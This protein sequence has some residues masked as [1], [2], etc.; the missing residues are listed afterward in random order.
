MYHSSIRIVHSVPVC[1]RES[2]VHSFQAT[3][4]GSLR[5]VTPP[6]E[7]PLRYAAQMRGLLR[8][9]RGSKAELNIEKASKVSSDIADC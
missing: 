8:L 2:Y 6:K 7:D 3:F 9:Q 4:K 5:R 1:S